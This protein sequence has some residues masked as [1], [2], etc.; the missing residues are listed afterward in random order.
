MV[1]EPVIP[2]VN[3]LETAEG[4]N[5]NILVWGIHQ[6]AVSRLVTQSFYFRF[7]KAVVSV[8][9]FASSRLIKLCGNPKMYN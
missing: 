2:L 9:Y 1:T 3:F 6:I 7:I 4:K 5:Q 8:Q